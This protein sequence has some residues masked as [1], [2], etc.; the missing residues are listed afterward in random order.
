VHL[1]A[2][3]LLPDVTRIGVTHAQ[4]QPFLFAIALDAR[5]I[6]ASW[7]INWRSVFEKTMPAD[8]QVH[9]RIIDGDGILETA[10]SVEPMGA[11]H[12][13]KTSGLH[14]AYR[15]EI[16]YFQPFDIWNSVATSGDVEMPPQGRVEL[17]NVDLATIPFHISFQ[18][19]ANLFGTAKD[20]SIAI[21]RVAS[22][23]QK[24]VLSNGER[25]EARRLDRRILSSLNLSL[26]EIAAAERDFRK[27]DSEKL[28]RHTRAMFQVGATS[29]VQGFQP[30]VAGVKPPLWP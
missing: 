11:T 3:R 28:A 10:V 29:P 17:A 12:Y 8:R 18:Q 1:A 25:H 13:V 4:G 30:R 22:E 23:F 6:F 16:G 14:N 19:L 24:R 5:T 7:N 20:A 15:V 21:A 26:D 27:I 2:D 9:L